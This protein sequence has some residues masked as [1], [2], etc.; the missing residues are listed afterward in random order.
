MN[1]I[2]AAVALTVAIWSVARWL[3]RRYAAHQSEPHNPTE[4]WE[5]EGGA[6]SSSAWTQSSPAFR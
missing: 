6:L 1:R 4:R 5:N 2:I 3:D